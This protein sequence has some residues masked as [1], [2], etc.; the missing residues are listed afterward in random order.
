MKMVYFSERLAYNFQKE[1]NC[2]L[3]L[4]EKLI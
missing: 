4:L 3:H 1:K 2:Q